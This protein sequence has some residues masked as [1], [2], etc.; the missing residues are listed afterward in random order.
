MDKIKLKRLM[1]DVAKGHI[2]QKEADR[3]IKPKKDDEE[4]PV[5]EIEGE[6]EQT[7]KKTQT[8][9]LNP[10]GGKK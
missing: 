8:R 4:K 6:K 9:K 7:T 2:T 10:T 3:L 1:T 5:D